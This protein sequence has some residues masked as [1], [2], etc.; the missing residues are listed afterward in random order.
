MLDS[1]R[2]YFATK[3]DF[4]D[5][6]LFDLLDIHNVYYDTK[7]TSKQEIINTFDFTK[8]DNNII[9]NKLNA[10]YSQ[11]GKMLNSFDC[12]SNLKFTNSSIATIDF[13]IEDDITY[14][15]SYTT[16]II[17][18]DD[19]TKYDKRFHAYMRPEISSKILDYISSYEGDLS[20]IIKF[21]KIHIYEDTSHY[22]EYNIEYTIHVKESFFAYIK[23]LDTLK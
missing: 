12:I 18:I 22:P 23:L 15:I 13:R 3:K 8:K 6:I 17:F 4:T 14:G 21:F 1:F 10:K 5:F 2:S 20:E 11:Y 7:T 16:R 9:E 19:N